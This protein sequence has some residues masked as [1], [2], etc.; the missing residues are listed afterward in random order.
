MHPDVLTSQSHLIVRSAR[1]DDIAA[2]LTI[3]NAAAE[4]YRDTIPADCWHEPYMSTAE[5]AAELAAGVKFAMCEADGI[6]LG[7]MGIQ[8]VHD[9][10][11]IR[12]AYVSP[13][14][15]KRGIGTVLIAHLRDRSSRQIL[16]GTWA[17][18]TWAIRFYE[19]QGFQRVPE[20]QAA[21]LLARYW[22]VSKRQAETSVVLASPPLRDSTTST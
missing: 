20:R 8:A 10:D 3:I 18:A 6:A 11:L 5:L 17:A 21:Q 16:V 4:A 13:E 14:H 7:L 15:Q 2:M 19:G 1:Q 9:V 22:T 12:H